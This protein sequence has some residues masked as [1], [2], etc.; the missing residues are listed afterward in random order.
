IFIRL[1]GV[2]ALTYQVVVS[3]VDLRGK[4]MLKLGMKAVLGVIRWSKMSE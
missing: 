4:A 3:R 2:S 1:G